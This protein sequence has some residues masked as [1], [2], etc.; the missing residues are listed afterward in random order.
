[1]NLCRFADDQLA[2]TPYLAGDAITAADLAV[3]DLCRAEDAA[4]QYRLKASGGLG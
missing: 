4:G 2:K 1:M 3:P